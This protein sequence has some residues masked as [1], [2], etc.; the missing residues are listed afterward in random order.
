MNYDWTTPWRDLPAGR[1]LDARVSEE[2]F[3]KHVH[4]FRA[5]GANTYIC[6][7]LPTC[8]FRGPG[9]SANGPRSYSTE[10]RSVGKLLDWVTE[11]GWSW[12]LSRRMDQVFRMEAT[13]DH[14][15]PFGELAI[16]AD[17]RQTY[18]HAVCRLALALV[19][20]SP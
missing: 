17:S 5:V 12:S 2:V 7:R 10:H 13:K 16:Y 1:D 6:T 11:Q 15:A 14:D 8:D 19:D 18:M 3:G 20:A 4:H 9:S